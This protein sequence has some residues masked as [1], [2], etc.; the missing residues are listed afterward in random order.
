MTAVPLSERLVSMLRMD[1]ERFM[2]RAAVYFAT[3]QAAKEAARKYKKGG[4][5]RQWGGVL[6]LFV[7][8]GHFQNALNTVA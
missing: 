8:F 3:P 2:G 1:G 6:L 7:F 5:F 4:V